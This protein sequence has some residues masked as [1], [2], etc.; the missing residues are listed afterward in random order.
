VDSQPTTL[1]PESRTGQGFVE[2]PKGLILALGVGSII[3]AIVIVALVVRSRLRARRGD[4]LAPVS[5]R[6][7]RMGPPSSRPPR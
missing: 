5:S 1:P 3:L 6:G 2:G 7:S 4:D